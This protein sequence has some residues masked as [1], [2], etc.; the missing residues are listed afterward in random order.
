MLVMGASGPRA[1]RNP[2]PGTFLMATDG[3]SLGEGGLL[4]GPVRAD[5]LPYQPLPESLL[6]VMVD[7]GEGG[8]MWVKKKTPG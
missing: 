7:R 2:S 1:P 6:R 3:E 8:F 4:S 5:Y